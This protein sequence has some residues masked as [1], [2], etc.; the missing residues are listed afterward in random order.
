MRIKTEEEMDDIVTKHP[1]LHWESWNVVR[2][3]QDDYAEY[4][5]NGLIRDGKWYR[6]TIYYPDSEGWD[7]PPVLIK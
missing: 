2:L 7:I 1:E 3:Q 5:P 6:Q 4:L